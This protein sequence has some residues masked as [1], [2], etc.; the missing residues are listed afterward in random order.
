MEP[1]PIKEF[2]VED[3]IENYFA[4]RRKDLLDYTRGQYVRLELG[5]ASGRI[6]A[7]LWEPDQF[8]RE[9]LSEGMVVKVRGQVTEYNNKLQVT[10]S[11]VRLARDDEYS[12]ETILPHSS[13]T[14]EWRQARIMK[15]TEKVENSYI[16]GLMMAFWED[17]AFLDS[18]N[19]GLDAGRFDES[20]TLPV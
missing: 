2:V 4:V 13:Q 10:I 3:R 18:K 14:S 17:E 15:L 1:K 7:V 20:R 19:N 9:E 16:K 8:A 5:D 12:L 11:K 6:K